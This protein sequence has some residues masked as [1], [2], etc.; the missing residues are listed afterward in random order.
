MN[1]MMLLEMAA[2]G[3][4]DRVAVGSRHGGGLTYQDLYQAAGRAAAT[5]RAEA[6]STVTMAVSYT[7]LD[8]F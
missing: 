8:M 6:P 1:L 4:G 3:F 7:H 5:I 2:N